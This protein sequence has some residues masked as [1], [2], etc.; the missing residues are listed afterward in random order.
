MFPYTCTP[1][2]IC[3]VL[4]VVVVIP[5]KGMCFLCSELCDPGAGI[6]SDEYIGR[7]SYAS[8]VQA[9]CV[10]LMHALEETNLKHFNGSMHSCTSCVPVAYTGS[11]LSNA[12]YMQVVNNHLSAKTGM[13]TTSSNHSWTL[14][15]PHVS[16]K[17]SPSTSKYRSSEQLSQPLSTKKGIIA[18]PVRNS[19]KRGRNKQ[20]TTCET[21]LNGKEHLSG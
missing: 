3:M 14:L 20:Q 4:Q 17:Q 18:C 12:A 10:I 15:S 13:H 1:L 6:F 16:D 21:L 8:L 5:V 9:K 19:T 2:L 11:Y 7:V